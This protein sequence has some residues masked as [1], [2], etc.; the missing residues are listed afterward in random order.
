MSTA[1]FLSQSTLET[2]IDQEEVELDGQSL[3]LLEDSS[4][5]QLEPAVYIDQVL[6]GED[7]RNLL[8]KTCTLAELEAV[9]A[10][11]FRNSVVLGETA[12]EGK[13]GFVVVWQAD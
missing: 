2:W 5:Y 7:S 4:H 6:D 8:G 13:E 11:C 3:R 9:Q 10:D 12:Y 1:L